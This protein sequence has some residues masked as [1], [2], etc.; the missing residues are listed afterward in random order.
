MRLVFFCG[1]FGP[2]EKD[3]ATIKA[4]FDDAIDEAA[5]TGS[6]NEWLRHRK[7][8]VSLL[9]NVMVK[10]FVACGDPASKFGLA[11][12]YLLR[13]LI[14]LRMISIEEGSKADT[15]LS[16]SLEVLAACTT[17]Q[18]AI[19]DEGAFIAA[20]DRLERL[21]SAGYFC[22]ASWVIDFERAN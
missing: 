5:S 10:P 4:L 14:E 6:Q 18:F 2:S 8:V 19:M 17:K 13:N 12:Y 11:V 20:R 7:R 1:A 9:Q 15:A 21:Q 3:T 22:G 16:S